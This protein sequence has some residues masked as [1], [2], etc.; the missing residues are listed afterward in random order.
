MVFEENEYNE[1]GFF[2]VMKYIS[3]PLN[4]KASLVVRKLV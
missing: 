1:V 4:L 3:R 2:E